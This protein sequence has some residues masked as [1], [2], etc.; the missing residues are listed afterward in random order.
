MLFYYMQEK[1]NLLTKKYKKEEMPPPAWSF[2]LTPGYEDEA[3]FHFIQKTFKGAFEFDVLYSS[4]SAQTPMTCK[5]PE[6]Y[7]C[8]GLLTPM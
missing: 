2:A 7:R 1:L 4:G 6:G 5:C 8:V 3:N